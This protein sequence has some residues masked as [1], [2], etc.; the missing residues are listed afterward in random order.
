MT[1]TS[2]KPDFRKQVAA[3]SQRRDALVKEVGAL[4]DAQLTFQP[5]PGA[6]SIA[7]IIEHLLLVEGGIVERVST[8]PDSSGFP[9]AGAAE[10]AR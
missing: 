10:G 5:I 4:P 3:L 1:L 8:V 9:T 7:Q 2:L 6:W